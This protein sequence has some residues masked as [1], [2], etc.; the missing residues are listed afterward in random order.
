MDES[1]EAIATA[2]GPGDLII[3]LGAGNVSSAAEKILS[4][5]RAEAAA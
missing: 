5:L 1:V 4:R 3:T 2:A